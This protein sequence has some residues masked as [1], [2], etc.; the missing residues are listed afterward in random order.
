[1]VGGSAILRHKVPQNDKYSALIE[2]LSDLTVEDCEV[3]H[4]L[5]GG[6]LLLW[7]VTLGH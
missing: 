4:K 3:S 7:G 2:V 6:I 1:M 5:P